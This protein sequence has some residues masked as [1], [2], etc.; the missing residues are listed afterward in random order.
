[1]AA[2]SAADVERPASRKC[3]APFDELAKLRRNLARLPRREADAVKEA[4]DERHELQRSWVVDVA[5][6]THN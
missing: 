1:V 6:V 4:V 5:Y 2:G 3:V